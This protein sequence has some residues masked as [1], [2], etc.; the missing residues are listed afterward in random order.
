LENA[1]EKMTK[2]ELDKFDK[3][4]GQ[5][6][7]EFLNQFDDKAPVSLINADRRARRKAVKRFLANYWQCAKEIKGE[8]LSEPR[9]QPYSSDKLGHKSEHIIDWKE[10]VEKQLQKTPDDV[11]RYQ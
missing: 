10:V 9:N 4:K 7:R 6:K 3:L 8:D 5:E 2:E 11:V 1:K